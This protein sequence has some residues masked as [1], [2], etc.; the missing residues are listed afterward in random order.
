MLC[1]LLTD[2]SPLALSSAAVTLHSLAQTPEVRKRIVTAGGLTVTSH[3]GVHHSLSST[4]ASQ[5][6][7]RRRC[8]P[9]TPR[10]TT[11]K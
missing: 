7:R 4:Q 5:L 11:L 3:Y 9:V 10:V 6:N 2:R 1:G 8:V